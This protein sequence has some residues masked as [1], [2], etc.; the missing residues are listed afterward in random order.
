MKKAVILVMFLIL[1]MTLS[2]MNMNAQNS[3]ESK[4][5]LLLIDIQYFYF[6]GAKQPLLN[7]EEASLNAQ[8]LLTHFRNT[9]QL[10]I[11]VR[12]NSKTGG[13]IHENVAPLE[14]EKIISKSNVNSFKDTDL[15]DFLKTNE[16][17]KLVICGMMTHMCVEAAV[18]AASD[19]DFEV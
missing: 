1:F 9:D 14:T 2:Q 4:P 18:R 7:P 5:A 19:Y 3:E 6:P 10:V 16:V 13:E 11:H 17:K 15:L 8:K 12:H